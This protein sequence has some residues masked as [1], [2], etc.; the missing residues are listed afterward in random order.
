MRVLW[1]CAVLL[2]ATIL[3][4]G[5]ITVNTS[6]NTNTP[7][8]SVSYSRQQQNDRV[9]I[10]ATLTSVGGPIEDWNQLQVAG[11]HAPEEGTI[12]VPHRF[13]G[14]SGHLTIRYVETGQTLYS[15]SGP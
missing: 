12:D 13:S 2:G 10:T 5:C 4:S 8:V 6:D 1:V 9:T 3:A 15:S 7:S 11:C 14:C